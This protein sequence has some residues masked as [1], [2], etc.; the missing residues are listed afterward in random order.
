MEDDGLDEFLGSVP[1]SISDVSRETLLANFSNCETTIV[2]EINGWFRLDNMCDNIKMTDTAF[3]SFMY[4]ENC[5]WVYRVRE[6]TKE[7]LVTVKS[8]QDNEDDEF[9]SKV[10]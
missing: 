5:D 10:G 3:G 4:C 1:Q 6:R 8:D 7:D 9:L 2:D